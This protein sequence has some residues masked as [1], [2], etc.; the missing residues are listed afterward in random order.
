MYR[1]RVKKIVLNISTALLLA[2][3]VSFPFHS[4]PTPPPLPDQTVR[5]MVPYMKL[6]DAKDYDA[7]AKFD[8]ITLPAECKLR[9]RKF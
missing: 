2:T 5:T 4:S 8:V 3:T 7:L 9:S 1:S 6:I